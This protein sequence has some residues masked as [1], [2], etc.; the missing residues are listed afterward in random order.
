M[1]DAIFGANVWRKVERTTTVQP[2]WMHSLRPRYLDRVGV[3]KNPV[4]MPP[5]V[6]AEHGQ[7]KLLQVSGSTAF[8][9]HQC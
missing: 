5:H 1:N 9:A 8:H 6:Y 7:A 2:I 3:R 4:T